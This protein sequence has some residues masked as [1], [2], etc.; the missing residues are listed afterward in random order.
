M[1]S[2]AC[3]KAANLNDP[4]HVWSELEITCAT[5]C[6]ENLAIA[7]QK[8]VEYEKIFELFKHH[9]GNLLSDEAPIIIK[10]RILL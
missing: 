6:I 2:E 7:E 9:G 5:L 4:D 10:Q 1:L 8:F 3:L